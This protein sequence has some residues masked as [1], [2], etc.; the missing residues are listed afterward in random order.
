MPGWQPVA[1]HGVG[2]RSLQVADRSLFG[3]DSPAPWVEQS[4]DAP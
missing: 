3:A 4:L 2:L 1:L